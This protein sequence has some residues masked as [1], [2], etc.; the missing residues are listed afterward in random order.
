VS[1]ISRV[2]V[3]HGPLLEREDALAAL[4]GAYSETRAGSG[5]FAFV[6][7]EAGIGKTSLVHA[8]CDS[9]RGSSRILEGTCDP[10]FTP[11]PL[12][13]L[14]EVAALTGGALER[15]VAEGSVREIANDLVDELGSTPTVLVLEDLHWADEATLDLLR[16][17]GR[18]VA[19]TST[20]VVATFRDDELDRTHPLRMLLGG[21]VTAHGVTRIS[22]EPLSRTAVATLAEGYAVDVERLFRTTSGNPFFVTQVLESGGEEIP[23]TVRDATLARAS[24]LDREAATILELVAVSPP[25]IEA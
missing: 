11:R 7:G 18:L 5:R 19:D 17:I 8:F 15:A 2:G 13:P 1:T 20:L 4:H 22:L 16:M 14:E 21:F 12:A 24:R 25:R 3:G 10:L 23:Q 6:A 9:V